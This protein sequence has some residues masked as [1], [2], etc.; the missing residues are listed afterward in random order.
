[1]SA[2]GYLQN[3]LPGRCSAPC[4]TWVV[5]GFCPSIGRRGYLHQQVL[6]YS[7]EGRVRVIRFKRCTLYY[8]LRITRTGCHRQYAL[9]THTKFTT[10]PDQKTVLHVTSPLHSMRGA[11]VPLDDL[12]RHPLHQYCRHTLIFRPVPWCLM[13]CRVGWGDGGCVGRHLSG[14]NNHW[15]HF[16][17]SYCTFL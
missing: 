4:W 16:G 6:W 3:A 2:C 7:N 11:A 5:A 13:G 17:V 10:C 15:W 14:C 8:A 12:L 1:M 9:G